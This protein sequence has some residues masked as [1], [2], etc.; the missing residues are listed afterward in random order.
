MQRNLNSVLA[1]LALVG[2]ALFLGN[3]AVAQETQAPAA[4]S[5]EDQLKA[6]FATIKKCGDNGTVLVVQQ[7]GITG[8]LQSD[9][10]ILATRYRDGKLIPPKFNFLTKNIYKNI[11]A[12]DPNLKVSPTAL[13]VNVN[14]D[15]IAMDILACSIGHKATVVFEFPKGNLQKMGVP[16]VMD[17]IGKVFAFDQGGDPGPQAQ[18]QAPQADQQQ[19]QPDGSQA[20]PA[21][22]FKIQIG[23]TTE[24]EVIAGMGQPDQKIDAGTK[25]IF[26]YKN[27]K[28]T[29]KDGKVSDVE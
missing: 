13:S 4:P 8:F 16:D 18:Q 2:C 6:Q 25:K 17:T 19:Q 28:V 12:F 11:S 7:S 1:L 26:M 23:Q 15:S 22:P 29:F 3:L 14:Q 24:K 10:K 21:E 5:L 9:S 27:L 20:Q